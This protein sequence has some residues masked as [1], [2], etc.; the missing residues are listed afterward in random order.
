MRILFDTNV[1]ISYLLPTKRSEK[2]EKIQRVIEAGFEGKYTFVV[3][4][5][6]LDEMKKKISEKDYL[7]KHITKGDAEEFISLFSEIAECLPP[8]KEE[9]PAV[10]RDSKDDYLLAYAVVGECD[11]LVSGDDDLLELKQIGELK[12]VS[13]AVF[14]ESV[15]KRERM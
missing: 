8:I 14:Y 11:Y 15:I 3:P 5:E 2:V 9:I 4:Q 10:S 12:I 7:V 13:P 6:L 1:F